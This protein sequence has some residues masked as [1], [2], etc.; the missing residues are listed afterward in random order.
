MNKQAGAAK[1]K[2]VLL[3]CLKNRTIYD[4]FLSYSYREVVSGKSRYKSAVL[5]FDNRI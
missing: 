3:L 1:Q 2:T 5:L 4:D